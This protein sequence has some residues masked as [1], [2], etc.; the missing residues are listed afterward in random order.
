[1][2]DAR[3]A[4]DALPDERRELRRACP[5]TASGIRA[6]APSTESAGEGRVE[7]IGDDVEVG[8]LRHGRRLYPRESAC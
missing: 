5:R 3:D 1:M 2:P 8:Q 4:L 7:G 6:R